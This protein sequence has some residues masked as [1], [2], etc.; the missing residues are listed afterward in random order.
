MLR[1]ISET[2]NRGAAIEGSRHFYAQHGWKLEGQ[3]AIVAHGG[4]GTFVAWQETRDDPELLPDTS[5]MR[6][7][8]HPY[9]KPD[10]S[11]SV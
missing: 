9:V 10:A 7:A 3:K 4:R 8:R 5:I 11:C 2:G 1:A 6:H